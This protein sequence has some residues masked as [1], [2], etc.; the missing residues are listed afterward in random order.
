MVGGEGQDMCASDWDS[1][2]TK[3]VPAL[4]ELRAKSARLRSPCWMEDHCHAQF[5]ARGCPKRM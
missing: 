4:G 3:A 2:L 1:D 5:L